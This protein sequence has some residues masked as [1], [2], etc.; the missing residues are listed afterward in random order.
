MPFAF[1]EDVGTPFGRGDVG[2]FFEIV[3]D[4]AS[5]L[6]RRK[7]RLRRYFP[8]G[9]WQMLYNARHENRVAFRDEN[10]FYNRGFGRNY[11][12]RWLVHDALRGEVG[13]QRAERDGD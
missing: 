2:E 11:R 12:P 4:R 10:V 13:K 3:G 8:D 6:I 7:P 5:R 1:F 9:F